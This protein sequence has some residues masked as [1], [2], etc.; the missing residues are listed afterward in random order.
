MSLRRR[1]DIRPSP[2]LLL[3]LSKHGLLLL[4]SETRAKRS[5]ILH[6]THLMRHLLRCLWPRLHGPLLLRHLLLR[7][8]RR[9]CTCLLLH[10]RLSFENR[11][12][13]RK[14]HLRLLCALH[15]PLSSFLAGCIINLKYFLSKRLL[16]GSELRHE[17][18]V[19]LRR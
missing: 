3:L 1:A 14:A 2:L 6:C 17:Q 4:R 15:C 16:Q 11:A 8:L 10:T 18:L 5:S 7:L 12:E 13:L 9:K 19:L